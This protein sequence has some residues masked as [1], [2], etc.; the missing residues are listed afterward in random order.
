MIKKCFQMPG[1][2]ARLYVLLTASIVPIVAQ[3]A[4]P[5]PYAPIACPLPDTMDQ[6]LRDSANLKIAKIR[7]NQ[8]GYR[9]QDEKLFY[10]IGTSGTAFSIVD[11]AKGTVVAT[12]ALAATTTQVST[13]L[14][15]KCYYK[16]SI[17][18]NGAV[19]Y[20]LT[21]PQISGTIYKGFVPDLP[22]GVYKIAV[23]ADTSAQFV[24][25]SDIYS[26]VKDAVLK[27]FGVARCG[28]NDS[29]FHPPC[30][31]KDPVPGG[32]H[33]AGDHLKESPS[34]G[35]AMAVLGLCAAALRDR[36]LDHYAKNQAI[37]LITDGIPDVLTEAK[38]GAD[39]LVNSWDL[40]GQTVTGM[41]TK[42]GDFGKDHGWWGRP[43][44]QDAVPAER[45]GPPRPADSGLG[46]N[47]CGSFSAGL[48]FVGKLY[49]PY[50]PAYG[51]KCIQI[52]KALYAYGKANPKAYQ[53][54]ALSGSDRTNDEMAFGA[55]AL[56]WA[57]KDS[58]Y[59]NDLLYDKTIG[60]NAQPA[61]YPKGGFAGGWFTNKQAGMFKDVANTSWADQDAY[62][63]WGLFRLIL[64]ND[65]T[66]AS[67]GISAAERLNL[68]EDVL[69]CQISNIGDISVGDQSI[70]LPAPSFQWK[71]GVLKCGSDWGW[72]LVELG[73]S[74]MPNRYQCGN[75]TELFCYYDVASKMQGVDLPN[76][77]GT[78]DWKVNDVKSVLLKQLN[79]MLGM[80][81]WDVSMI[82]GVGA[83]CLNHPHHRAATPELQNFPGAFYSYRPPVGA[84][85][86]GY[87]PTINL[88]NEYMGGGD[89]Y[90]HTEVSLDAATSIFLPIMGMAKQD[91]LRAPTA[92]VRTI[93]VG[94]DKAIIEVRQSRYGT[95]AINYGLTATPDKSK[96]S[97]SAGVLQTITLTGLTGG[98]TYYFKVDVKDLFGKDSVITNID[99]DKLPVPFTF[100]TLQNCPTSAT[101]TNV[102][103]CSVTNDSAEIF[104]YTSNGA[105]DSKVV[106]GTGKP[107]AL[108]QAGDISG[109]PVN[110]HFVKLGGLKEQTT[111]YFYVQSG[112]TVDNNNGLYYQFTTAVKHV[113]FDIRA[114]T[115]TWQGMTALGMD[116]IN[117]EATAYDSLEL[118][119]YFRATDA[120]NFP[121]DLA[122]RMDIG[123]WYDA[124]GF[125]HALDSNTAIRSAIS[126]Q[127]PIKMPDTYNPADGTYA[128]YLTVPLWGVTMDAEGRIRLDI[129]FDS[130][131]PNPPYLD[132]MNKPPKHQINVNDWSFGPHSTPVYFPGVPVGLKDD[133]DNNYWSLPIDYYITVYR[134]GE[135]IWGYSPSAAEQE[136]KKNFYTLTT[137]ATS[138]L[139]NPSSDYVF[140][141]RTIPSVTVSGWATVSPTDGVINDIWVNGVRLQSP[142]SVLQWNQSLNR[143][144]FT[145]PV[146]V[147]SGSNPV[148]ITFFAGPSASCSQCY[149]CAVS[150]H[151]FVIEFQG[152][153]QYTSK[154]WL[155]DA[156]L[157][158]II[159][160]IA[161][162]DTTAFNVVVIDTNGNLD[163]KTRDT[164]HATITD[165]TSGDSMTVALIETGD[166][167]SQFVSTAPVSV[168]DSKTSVD[169]IVMGP[170]DLLFI[171][172]VDPTDPTDSSSAFLTSKATFPLAVRGWL[173]DANGDGRAD[174]AIVLYNKALA[175]APDSLRFYFPDTFFV[176]MVK[177]GQGSIRASG[178]MA[179]VSFAQPFANN[180][181]AFSGASQGLDVSYFTVQGNAKKNTFP[182]SDSIGPVITSAQAVERLS[183]GVD[184]LYIAFSESV[185]EQTLIGAS[186]ILI[187][188]GIST[189]VSIT[190]YQ[191][192]SGG[193]YSAVLDTASPAP[194]AGDSLRINPAG[195]LRDQIGNAAHPLNRPV[196]L[197]IK[198][199]PAG[200]TAAWYV[201]R[202]NGRAD[203]IVDA[204]VVRF[205]KKVSLQD[206]SFLVDW[207]YPFTAK[208]VRDSGLSYSGTDSMTVNVTLKNAFSPSPGIKT[209]GAMLVTPFFSSFPGVAQGVPAADSAAPVIDSVSLISD[210]NCGAI[211]TLL[212]Y[213]SEPILLT[214]STSPINVLSK[215]TNT[216][217]T[218]SFSLLKVNESS[219]YFAVTED[220][221]PKNGDSLW[222]NT[223]PSWARDTGGMYQTNPDNRKTAI[224]VASRKSKW[225]D[226]FVNINPFTPGSD[227]NAQDGPQGKGTFITILPNC[228]NATMNI[229]TTIKIF[230]PLGNFIFGNNS[231]VKNGNSYYVGWDGYTRNGR[232]AGTGVYQAVVTIKDED[233]NTTSVYKLRV[234]VKR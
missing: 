160:T 55:L 170:G 123:F 134:K 234:G 81:P 128:Y 82:T 180:T 66:A 40:G 105:F 215:T 176:Q 186:L 90:F 48:A 169:Q 22:E 223:P 212:V 209:S 41:K 144:D 49:Q 143:Y 146:P 218:P 10:A 45:G 19:K 219:A 196:L 71:Q 221:A 118:R 57:T 145:I 109:H 141:K 207:G 198:Q 1:F 120:D 152:A 137:Q 191:K 106:Y 166:S 178:A 173:L 17:V 84:L 107:P 179:F 174:S 5:L 172:Y 231:P 226:P 53:D 203:G 129:V 205:N 85:S 25:R 15:M 27:Y 34:I 28:N 51:A 89:G 35:Y 7:I 124:A 228:P 86:G 6:L 233:D 93:Y 42:I 183:K 185:V 20:D 216:T 201:D 149:G 102:K 147:H 115:Y 192:L 88:Y 59:K 150:N 4:D 232:A 208:N 47:T 127:K 97:D 130:R 36:D 69:Y 79:Y 227:V 189:A 3:T 214:S 100:T 2:A 77:P 202:E 138:P 110:F 23:G 76:S 33:D 204:A 206:L 58:L 190:A 112:T 163:G 61:L 92:T 18:A 99:Q 157:Q 95:S 44:Y 56:W 117:Q 162:I 154:L 155:A 182:V 78:T 210:P 181:T 91:T 70:T 101:I 103:I 121:S 200:V 199:I 195:P 168:V 80:N 111:Y 39:Y 52:A 32:W 11:A 74:W 43:E 31:L 177:T 21:S 133:V 171:K 175:A 96:T 114:L 140:F 98:T 184:T 54:A 63:L 193:V 132:L 65:S 108:V 8:A 156:A 136:T 62:P 159:D 167:T 122:A 16:A 37:T 131:S 29:W 38:V 194:R 13:K 220:Q 24:I 188:N 30:H 64:I 73:G 142:A 113:K 72:M 213:F 161:H 165:P 119:L 60:P 125:Q 68:I 164:L 94:C 139:V 211:D 116:V 197:G 225:R 158:P 153:K 9:P 83:K 217:R 104:W 67:Y 14:E 75:I 12:G 50:D 229:S 222:I 187:H 26:M 46:G 151:H 230:D 126:G 224:V 87:V 148:D 135:Y